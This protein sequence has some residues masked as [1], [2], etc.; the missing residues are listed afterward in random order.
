MGIKNIRLNEI[1]L[2]QKNHSY[3][4]NQQYLNKIVCV[5]IEK[6]SK[7]S[8]EF[9]SGRTTQNTFVVFPKKNFSLGDFV[10]V[11]VE[12]CTSATLIGEGLRISKDI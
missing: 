3:F 10:D 2:K 1:I 11:R 6:E 4:R 8:D 7:K 5:L 12:N 9:W